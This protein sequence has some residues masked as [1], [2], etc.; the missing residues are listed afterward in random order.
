MKT[1]EG[2]LLCALSV[3]YAQ[4]VHAQAFEVA[5]ATIADEG[6]A[7]AEGRVTSKALVQAYLDRIEAFDRRGPALNAVI[8]LNPNAFREAEALDRERAAQGPRGPLHGI[9]V[10]V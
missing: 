3:I 4:S 1:A 2:L 6:K 5:E 7:M 9:P 8:T 10:I